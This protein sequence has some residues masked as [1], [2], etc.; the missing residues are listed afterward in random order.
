MTRSSMTC[1]QV[2]H[3]PGSGP[4]FGQ[5]ARPGADAQA[6]RVRGGRRRPAHR[7]APPRPFV[8]HGRPSQGEGEELDWQPFHP[9][10]GRVEGEARAFGEGDHG[11]Q[12]TTGETHPRS[13]LQPFHPPSRRVEGEARAFGEGDHGDQETTG[14]T[15]PRS[16]LQPFHPPSGRV[17][18]EARGFGEGS[19]RTAAVIA[20]ALPGRPLLAAAGPTGGLYPAAD[21]YPFTESSQIASPLPQSEGRCAHFAAAVDAWHRLTAAGNRGAGV[22]ASFVRP[23]AGGTADE[24]GGGPAI[25]LVIDRAVDGPGAPRA[26]HAPDLRAIRDLFRGLLAGPVWSAV[27][28]G[29]HGRASR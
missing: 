4:F 11:D 17:E 21:E 8:P 20:A 9:P 5:S 13:G 18:G 16:G 6:G 22:L 28:K 29:S 24:A 7:A 3:G 19:W 15:H 25:G 12:E 27:D 26:G 23:A 2:T 10:S 1:R 14:E